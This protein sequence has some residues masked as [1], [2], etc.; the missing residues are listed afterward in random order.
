MQQQNQQ[1]SLYHDYMNIYES[2]TWDVPVF[3]HFHFARTNPT[4]HCVSL[5]IILD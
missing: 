1:K 3:L 4:P 2:M 5:F